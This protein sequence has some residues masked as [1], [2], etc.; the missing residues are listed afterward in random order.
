ML[1]LNKTQKTPLNI[2]EMFDHL[3][4]ICLKRISTKAIFNLH[5]DVRA[6]TDSTSSH[7]K[8]NESFANQKLSKIW[9]TFW[10]HT[11]SL[12]NKKFCLYFSLD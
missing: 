5:Y 4:K 1:F 11:L 6:A 3:K 9:G 10:F 2:P 8:L 7:I 12:F